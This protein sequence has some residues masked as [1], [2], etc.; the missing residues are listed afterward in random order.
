MFDYND[1][2]KFYAANHVQEQNDMIND[3]D[4]QGDIQEKEIGKA[5]IVVVGVGGGGNNAV[6]NMIRAGVNS[7]TF[8]VMNTDM[9]ALN[10][11]LVQPRNKIQLGA[12]L[13]G[14]LGAGAI[15][16]KGREAAEE[17]RDLIRETLKDVDLLFITAG[18]GGGTGTGAA[19]VIAEIAQ[20]LGIL[21]VGI[22]TKPFSFEG[23][24]RMRNAEEGIEK[25][26]NFVD[27][28]VVVPNQKLIEILDKNI[29]FATAFKYA[30][31]ILRQGVQ[32]ISDVIAHPSI[33]NLDFADIRTIL[34]NKG[35][36]HMGIGLGKAENR[37]I[38]AVRQAVYSPLIETDIQGAT[39]I[40]VN[41]V[42]GKEDLRLQEIDE[43]CNTIK[44]LI[45]PEA[46]IILGVNEVENKK[47]I[48]VTVIA[49]GFG[50][51][52]Q[53]KSQ[54]T[55]S[56]GSYTS[57]GYGSSGYGGY[58]PMP[59]SYTQG[60]Y[61]SQGGI[62]RNP[63]QGNSGISSSRMGVQDQNVPPFLRLMKNKNDNR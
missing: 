45:D 17:S 53:P 14:G 24:Q 51:K 60:G 23:P 22:V 26:K 6:N 25:L 5:K 59:N 30:D 4:G 33:I 39:G 3:Y 10:M 27:T 58:Q 1:N 40:I 18:M 43:I 34:S 38:E 55:S 49:T 20:A 12:K 46:N 54:P 44:Q 7:A 57:T 21:T 28:L 8:V 42:G 61:M 63:T 9:Q 56:F 52:T 41:I 62:R 50:D 13:T 19:P 35:L 2:G 36:A 48:E 32:G 47:D 15:P 16:E 11:S 37:V 29:S 31:D